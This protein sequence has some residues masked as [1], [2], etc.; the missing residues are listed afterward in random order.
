M[1]H[2]ITRAMRWTDDVSQIH[3][4]LSHTMV[5]LHREKNFAQVE[6]TVTPVVLVNRLRSLVPPLQLDLVTFHYWQHDRS[7]IA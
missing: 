6:W 2:V 5:R 4:T 7:H 1:W 3:S